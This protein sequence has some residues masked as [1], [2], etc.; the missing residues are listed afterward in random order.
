[1]KPLAP[2]WLA[3]AGI[4]TAQEPFEPIPRR[5]PPAGLEIPA[6]VR[7]ELADELTRL[8][9]IAENLDH[10]RKSDAGVFL[11]GV[12]F[13]LINGEFYAERDFDTA[14]QHLEIAAQRL[15]NPGSVAKT[16]LVVRGYESSIDGSIQPY[17]LET[18]ENLDLSKPVPLL[19][20]LHGRGDKTTDLHF[21]ER[22]R[23]RSQAFQGKI[24]DQQRCV[25]I[26]PFGR[27]CIGWKHAG[28]IDV[29]E[30]IDDA[31]QA[32][33]LVTDKR[34]L[35]GFSM[36]GAG[37]WHI[38]AHYPGL[39]AAIHAGAG[40]AETAEY[41]RLKP[42]DHPVW[43]EKAL[44]GLYDVPNYARNLLNVRVLAY[45]GENDKQKQ[46]ADLMARE[47]AKHGHELEH[48]I[49][50]GMGH[51]YHDEAVPRIFEALLAAEPWNPSDPLAEI[52]FQTRTLR[53]SQ[54]GP[55]QV[56]GLEEHWKDTRVDLKLEDGK[57]RVAATKNVSSLILPSG[58]CRI[59]GQNLGSTRNRPLKLRKSGETWEIGQLSGLRKRP[60]LQGPIDDAFMAPFLVVLPTKKSA[61]PAIQRWFD[62]EIAHFAKR[63]RE[64]FRGHPR[65]KRA[66]EVTKDDV[67]DFNLIC[68]GEPSTNAVIGAILDG[69][70]LI[71]DENL[72]LGEHRLDSAV[73]LP[74][75]IYPNP[76]NPQNYIV[77]NSGP[78][79]RENHDRT[80]SLQNPKLPDWALID[81]RQAPDGESPGKV[82]AADFFDEAW[83][84][85]E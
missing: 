37:A 43:Y 67:R 79:F 42:E 70:P 39:F 27:Q 11:K 56:T 65:L 74:A 49:G 44:W 60:R 57:T 76:R 58:P 64:L 77:L 34:L 75:L 84:V 40:F 26:H 35:A 48:V 1:M 29:F 45:S 53:Y 47:L 25:V 18:P 62:F 78:T 50:P 28:E 7:T 5:I 13:A 9:K 38:G 31:K 82:V 46:A 66:D 69:L 71:W 21:I 2:V 54:I 32:L 17:G 85:R 23:T 72:V 15:E 10:P 16:G 14:R 73:H 59:D 3:L 55:F 19:V 80:N 51:K 81:V 12:E 6:A 20:W 22:C 4:C 68:W 61:N 52:R 83:E 36:G 41:N 63:W 8:Q 30:A 33:G 24:T